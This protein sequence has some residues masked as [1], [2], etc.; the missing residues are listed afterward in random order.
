MGGQAGAHEEQHGQRHRGEEPG[1]GAGGAQAVAGQ[2]PVAPQQAAFAFRGA[3][4]VVAAHLA[5]AVIEVSGAGFVLAVLEGFAEVPVEGG[6]VLGVGGE[7]GVGMVQAG[8]PVA[9]R[10]G[11]G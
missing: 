5:L 8:T 11:V 10:G 3:G 9:G 2:Q 1:E 4:V 6:D 7:A